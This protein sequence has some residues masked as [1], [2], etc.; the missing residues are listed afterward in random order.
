[1]DFRFQ[2]FVSRPDCDN[3]AVFLHLENFIGFIWNL[4]KT[5]FNF[6]YFWFKKRFYLLEIRFNFDEAVDW[7]VE[8]YLELDGISRHDVQFPIGG[9]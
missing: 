4:E 7:H 1:M 5:V 2:T 8:R 6:H 9:D 3:L